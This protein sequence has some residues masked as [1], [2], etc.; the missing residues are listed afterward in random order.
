[1]NEGKRRAI[2]RETEM[3]E[4]IRQARGRGRA[5][6][7]R[8][9][10]TLVLRLRGQTKRALKATARRRGVSMSRIAREAL[11]AELEEEG[12]NE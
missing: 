5:S 9:D 2:E 7:R 8:W 4:A 12:P 10:S 1:M 3:Q 6:R 11:R